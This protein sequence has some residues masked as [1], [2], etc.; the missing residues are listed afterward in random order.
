M[1]RPG[2]L[3]IP[4][5]QGKVPA[6]EWETRVDLAA[7]YRVAAHDGYQDVTLNHFT[8]RVPGFPDRFLIKPTEL[9]FEEVTAS[10][11]LCFTLDN[12]AVYDS[13]F[14]KSPASFNIHG[15]ILK[16]RPDVGCTMHLHSNDAAAL[17]ALHGGLKFIS[18]YAMR[19]WG[20]LSYHSYE[21]LVHGDEREECLRMV[22]SLA[23]NNVMIMHNHG[24]LVCG[25]TVGEAFLFN[26][27]LERACQIQVRAMATGARLIEPDE[28]V[29]R[30][31]AQG[32]IENRPNPGIAGDRDFA[33]VKRQME[34]LDPSYAT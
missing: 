11:L 21:G 3:E 6:A 1:A 29:C 8:A 10:G 26:H 19:F 9:M 16:A 31:I 5:M 28:A 22:R 32:W 34:R 7:L 33:A 30:E 23:Q 27:Y 13:P 18:Q 17:S 15:S 20:K 12:K 4:S 2:W 25:R 24:T 14:S